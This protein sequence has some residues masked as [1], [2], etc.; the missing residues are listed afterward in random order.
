MLLCISSLPFS[1]FKAVWIIIFLDDTVFCCQLWLMEVSYSLMA[2]VGIYVRTESSNGL[3]GVHKSIPIVDREW[4]Q[5]VLGHNAGVCGRKELK[6]AWLIS[7][8]YHLPL[9]KTLQKLL[10]SLWDHEN[11]YGNYHVFEVNHVLGNTCRAFFLNNTLTY[12]L[13]VSELA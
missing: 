10:N 9:L 8:Q 12:P 1:I 7:L 13:H 6:Q 4:V 11:R 5:M 2:K 3:C